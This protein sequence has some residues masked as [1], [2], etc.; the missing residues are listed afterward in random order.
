MQVQS[1]LAALK[2][3]P[4]AAETKATAKPAPVVTARQPLMQVA[5]LAKPKVA[6]PV[7]ASLTPVARLT[8]PA[9]VS[10]IR[11]AGTGPDPM[12][13]RGPD[14]VARSGPNAALRADQLA[15]VLFSSYQKLTSLTWDICL[16]V[17][18][19]GGWP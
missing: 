17:K 10:T 19:I 2:K 6:V 12:F 11:Q 15:W 5:P 18:L 3:S 14:A 1:K 16:K 8:K 7:T 13:R 9:Y 4:A